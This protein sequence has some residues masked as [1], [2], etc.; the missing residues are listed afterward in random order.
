MEKEKEI[1]Y[2]CVTSLQFVVP[3]HDVKLLVTR[4][5][6]RQDPFILI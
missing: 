3:M 5:M 6:G 2:I 4:E 1:L